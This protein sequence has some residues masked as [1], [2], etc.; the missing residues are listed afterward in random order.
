MDQN[1]FVHF[2]KQEKEGWSCF[3]GVLLMVQILVSTDNLE[4]K[5]R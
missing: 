3:E 1:G 5:F 4:E 2:Q